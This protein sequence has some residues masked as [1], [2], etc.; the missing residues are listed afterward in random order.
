MTKKKAPWIRV[1]KTEISAILFKMTDVP[2]AENKKSSNTLVFGLV[3]KVILYWLLFTKGPWVENEVTRS[4]SCLNVTYLSS[5][6]GEGI[7]TRVETL[8]DQFV[9]D[10]IFGVEYLSECWLVGIWAFLRYGGKVGG[11]GQRSNYEINPWTVGL[12]M[13]ISVLIEI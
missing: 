6:M 12:Y 4:Y 1:G 9:Y 13:T 5:G 11:G 3:W 8:P 2:M 7:A 10:L